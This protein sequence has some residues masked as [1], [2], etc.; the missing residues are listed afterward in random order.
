MCLEQAVL[1]RNLGCAPFHQGFEYTS[2]TLG[3]AC[4]TAH[5]VSAN[6]D[7]V[8]EFGDV[9]GPLE[10]DHGSGSPYRVGR[11]SG[12]DPGRPTADLRLL[13][14]VEERSDPHL[15]PGF[16]QA[17]TPLDLRHI[18]VGCTH[19]CGVRLAL[20]LPPHRGHRSFESTA[21]LCPPGRVGGRRGEQGDRGGYQSRYHRR[22][23][24]DDPSAK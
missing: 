13:A 9:L 3:G 7:R 20:M 1:G 18:C 15:S 11:D 22:V 17:S 4:L 8:R 14:L 21:A 5:L 19:Q 12:T 24:A 2:G 16:P 6:G 10:K 23:H